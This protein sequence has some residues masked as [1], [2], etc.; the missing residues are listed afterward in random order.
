MN[1]CI[2]DYTYSVEPSLPIVHGPYDQGT[3]RAKLASLNVRLKQ[4]WR[5]HNVEND[6]S[7]QF[8]VDSLQVFNLGSLSRHLYIRPMVVTKHLE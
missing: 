8:N 4:R 3:A 7:I 1:Y 2:L 6:M 5:N